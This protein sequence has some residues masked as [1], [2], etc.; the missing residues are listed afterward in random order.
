MTFVPII[1]PPPQ[2]SPRAQ[3]LS[4]RVSEVV[5]RF[6]REHPDMSASE[7]RQALSM[8]SMRNGSSRAVLI[9]VLLGTIALVAATVLLV[10]SRT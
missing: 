9:A 2:P 5:E 8:A 10:L 4:R 3:E 6:R 1:V 7:I